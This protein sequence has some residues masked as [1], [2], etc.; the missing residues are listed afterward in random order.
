LLAK[1]LSGSS[2]LRPLLANKRLDPESINATRFCTRAEGD[3]EA[4]AA[5]HSFLR[6]LEERDILE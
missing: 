2:A 6:W 1:Q 3:E 5:A 4:N